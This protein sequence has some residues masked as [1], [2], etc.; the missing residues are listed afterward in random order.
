MDPYFSGIEQRVVSN[1]FVT[2]DATVH[3][4]RLSLQV[5]LKPG[6]ISKKMEY[7]GHIDLE[8]LILADKSKLKGTI[9]ELEL[10]GQW[11]LKS[12]AVEK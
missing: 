12:I 10:Q 5:T 6:H 11:L 8:N 9:E 2:V 1:D 3:N 7:F 4:Y